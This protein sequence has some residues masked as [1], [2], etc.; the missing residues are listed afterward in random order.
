MQ[1]TLMI[2]KPDAL[3]S[4]TL[5]ENIRLW[6]GFA[7]MLDIVKLVK[8]VLQKTIEISAR[9]VPGW[10]VLAKRWVVER[11]FALLNHFR[12]LSKDYE[13]SVKS[14]ENIIMISHSI[15]LIRRL[16]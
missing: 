16:T 14:A 15:F 11:T 6:K 5:F 7:Q 8:S 9:T 10:A 2:V 12:R 4:R 1:Q 13:I 3:F